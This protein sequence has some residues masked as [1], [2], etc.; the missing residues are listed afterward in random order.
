MELHIGEAIYKLRKEKGIKQE[1]LADS[2]GVSVAAVSKWE[3]K[4]SYPDITLLPSIARF[5]NTTIDRLLSYEIE[6]SNE[7]VMN[8]MKKCAAIF[9]KESIENGIRACEG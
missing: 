1:V 4:K 5:F 9:E 8:L 7:E 6:I 3:S 2:V